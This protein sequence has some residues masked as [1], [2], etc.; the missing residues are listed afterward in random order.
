MTIANPASLQELA[1][2]LIG[3]E[4]KS[5]KFF[6]TLQQLGLDNSYYQ[7]HLDEAILSCL[8]ITDNSNETFDRYYAVLEEH[9]E[10]IGT[11]QESVEEQAKNVMFKLRMT[12]R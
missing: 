7:P 12:L 8:G 4:L 11:K 3:E 10:K 6:N 2:V 9:A 1:A 5:R